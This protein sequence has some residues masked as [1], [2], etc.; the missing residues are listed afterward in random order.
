VKY[1]FL[2][3]RSHI[4]PIVI[5]ARDNNIIEAI[6]KFVI[7]CLQNEIFFKNNSLANVQITFN[8]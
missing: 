7:Y 1:L 3:I 6:F 8:V 4:I 5:K 2:Q